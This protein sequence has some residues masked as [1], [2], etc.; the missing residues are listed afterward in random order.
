MLARMTGK[1]LLSSS[2]DPEVIGGGVAMAQ[3]EGA[4]RD[5]TV[6]A[7]RLGSEVVP[8]TV[9]QGE[10]GRQPVRAYA[11]AE[12]GREL[13]AASADCDGRALWPPLICFAPAVRWWARTTLE[14][15]I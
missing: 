11:G 8:L 1:A 10:G 2:R 14:P 9:G 6:A 5:K 15:S 13:D 7:F 3:H 4:R 12:L